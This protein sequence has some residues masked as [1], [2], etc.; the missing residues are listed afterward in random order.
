MLRGVLVA[1]GLLLGAMGGASAQTAALP[2]GMTMHRLQAGAGGQSGSILAESTG[3]GFSVRLPVPFN[4]FTLTE[5]QAKVVRACSVGGKSGEGIKFIASRI[6]YTEKAEAERAFARAKEGHVAGSAVS[7]T[8]LTVDQ[9]PAVDWE[10]KGARSVAWMRWILIGSDTFSL[11]VETPL[12]F[13]SV[14][15]QFVPSFFGSLKVSGGCT[16]K[17]GA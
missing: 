15:K 13:E 16:G 4:D 8:E 14:A 10:M 17:P 3:G 12:E 9:A 11:S 7:V 5:R 6:V 1:S 2:E